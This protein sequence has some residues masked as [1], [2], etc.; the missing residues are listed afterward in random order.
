MLPVRGLEI[1]ALAKRDRGSR[2]GKVLKSEGGQKEIDAIVI[3]CGYRHHR[4][5]VALALRLR[6]GGRRN[7]QDKTLVSRRFTSKT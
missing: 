5:C 4:R 7:A 1:Q 3:C 2:K 6:F